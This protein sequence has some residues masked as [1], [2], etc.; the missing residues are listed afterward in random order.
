MGVIK[1]LNILYNYAE[2]ARHF[3]DM[4]TIEVVWAT[5]SFALGAL[6][7]SLFTLWLQLA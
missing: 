2:F 4:A 3:R 1:G 7:V 6:T 5:A